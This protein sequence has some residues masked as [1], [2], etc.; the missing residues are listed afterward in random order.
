MLFFDDSVELKCVQITRWS[1]ACWG[2]VSSG[3]L[4][5]GL[6]DDDELES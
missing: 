5:R 3:Q 2:E 4:R 6:C 1:G